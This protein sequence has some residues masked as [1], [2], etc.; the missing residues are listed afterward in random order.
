[1]DLNNTSDRGNILPNSSRINILL[2]CTQIFSRTDHVMPQNESYI[3]QKNQIISSLFSDH[4]DMKLQIIKKKIR[5]FTNTEIKQPLLINQWVD[6]EPKRK[7]EGILRQTETGPHI[8]V[9]R[10]CHESGSK[11][12]VQS[13]QH[14]HQGKKKHLKQIT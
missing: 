14:L 11:S 12:K 9:L 5:K 8:Q 6:K 1:M 13:N 2:K 4:N 7:P 10:G 3:F